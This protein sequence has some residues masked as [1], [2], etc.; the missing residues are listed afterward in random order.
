[1]H[2]SYLMTANSEGGGVNGPKAESIFFP[3][4]INL[5]DYGRK[6]VL[7]LFALWYVALL[8]DEAMLIISMPLVFNGAVL[9]RV[10][11]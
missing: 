11:C 10:D 7:A 4:H 1:M 9:N 6:Y 3:R 2:I 5:S 8:M